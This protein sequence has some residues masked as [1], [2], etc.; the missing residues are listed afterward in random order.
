M[1]C[2]ESVVADP[3]Q[4]AQKELD[5]MTR[6]FKVLSDESR[7]KI[8]SLLTRRQNIGVTEI[9]SSLNMSVS[10]VSHQLSML[11]HLGFVSREKIGR[12]VHHS[13][14]DPCILDILRK[15]KEHVSGY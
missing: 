7:L 9:A 13:I 12:R 4:L 11:E 5:Q 3:I 8:I 15:A 2:S 6:I 1:A 14:K 10:G